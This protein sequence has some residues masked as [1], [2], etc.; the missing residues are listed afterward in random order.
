MNITE[1][2]WYSRGIQIRL[3]GYQQLINHNGKKEPSKDRIRCQIGGRH[4]CGHEITCD[5]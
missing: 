5:M 1:N 3:Q 2:N 4:Q